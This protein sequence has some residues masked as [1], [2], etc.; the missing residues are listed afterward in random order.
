MEIDLPTEGGRFASGMVFVDERK[1]RLSLSVF[2]DRTKAGEKGLLIARN[3]PDHRRR[4][5]QASP[6]GDREQRSSFGPGGDRENNHLVLWK[7]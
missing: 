4:M 1:P 2:L 3:Q 6:K 7:A 5:L